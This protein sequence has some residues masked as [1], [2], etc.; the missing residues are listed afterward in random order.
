[1]KNFML[2]SAGGVAFIVILALFTI[3]VFVGFVWL[4]CAAIRGTVKLRLKPR[5]ILLILLAVGAVIRMAIAFSIKG[6]VGSGSLLAFDRIGYADTVQM[7]N[8]LL[9]QSFDSFM[10]VYGT[11]GHYPLTM[12]ILS[13]FG[14]INLLFGAISA[15]S[16]LTLILFKLPFILSDVLIAYVLYRITEKYTSSEIALAI[17]GFVAL[18]PVM[19]L[20]SIWPST[21][22]LLALVLALAMYFMLERKYVLLTVTY[23]ASLLVC[24][25]AVYLM[26]VISVF[27]IYAFI[28]KVI[29]FRRSNGDIKDREYRLIY[30]L[31]ITILA[32]IAVSYLI[33]LPFALPKIG[34][35]PFAILYAYYLKPLD[36]FKYFTYNGLSLFNVF[37]KNG[38]V[39]TLTF[40]I[41][42]LSLLFA[43]AII[44]VTLIIYLTKKNRANLVMLSSYLLLTLNVYFVNS[45][46]TNLLPF[47]AI[48]LIAF[49]I[50]K[51]RRMLKVLGIMALFTFLNAA[52]VLLK[53]DYITANA[54]YVSELLDGSYKIMSI[55]ASAVAVLCHLY[56]TFVLIDIVMNNTTK[57][58]SSEDGKLSSALKELIRIKD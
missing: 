41:W 30:V 48:M 46:E 15:E 29:A 3:V 42:V 26:P 13:F 31:P 12:Y 6:L 39:L 36:S 5:R 40:P 2:M 4:L 9:T 17:G 27:L 47:F 25:E 11:M 21:Y 35:N 49:A 50:I 20:G 7:V 37:G 38:D 57:K 23:S 32:C 19:M 14:A 51:D 10:N 8:V 58:L 1:M 33:L 24:F 53:A 55:V 56:Y 52:C 44:A 45:S 43:L 16:A 22:S 34:A 28:K 18:C 54:S